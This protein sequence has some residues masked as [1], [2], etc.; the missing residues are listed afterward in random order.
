MFLCKEFWQEV[1]KKR[2][3]NLKT[4]N[5]GVFVLQDNAFRWSRNLHVAGPVGMDPTTMRDRYLDMAA[6]YA[7]FPCGVVKV[8]AEA[9]VASSHQLRPP[10]C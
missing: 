8:R 6:N 7:C 2:V 5:R 3:D 1:F 9:Q 10:A 4:N